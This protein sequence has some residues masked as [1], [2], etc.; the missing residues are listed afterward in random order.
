MM[1]LARAQAAAD[2]PD[3]QWPGSLVLRLVLVAMLAVALSGVLSAWLASRASERESIRRLV[4]QQTEEVE[5]M[6]RLLASKIEQSQKV[7]RTVAEGITPE[8]LNS[9]SSLEW[10]LQQG[11]PAVQFFDSMQVARQDGALRVNLHS[12]RLEDAANLDPSERDA[13]RRTL[14]GGKP[15]VSELVAG[16]TAEARVMFTMPLRREDGSVMGVVA[17]ALKLQSQ[18]LLPPSMTLPARDDSRLIVFTRDGTILSHPDPLRILG[19]VRDETGLGPVYTGW[20]QQAQPV[21]GRGT[22]EV[23]PAHIVSMAGMP[24]PQWFVARVSDARAMLAPLEGAQRKA[25]WLA[26]ALIGASMALLAGLMVWMAQP[27]AQLCHSA[28]QLA[29]AQRGDGIAWP[30]A[31]GEV[32]ALVQVF[33]GQVQHSAQQRQQRD[34]LEGQFQ[35]IL[36]NASVG[37]VIT[38]QGI[39]EVVGRQ[40]CQMLGYTT[41]ELQGRAA[42]TLYASDEDYA[43]LGERVQADFAAHAAFDGDVCFM[44][45]DG[46]PVWARVQGR[47][48]RPHDM[49][50]GTVWI[51]EDLTAAREAQQQQ[52]WAAIHD[53]LTQLCNREAFVQRMGV[54]L[55]ERSARARAPGIAAAD[56]AE[57]EGDGV[58]LFLDLDYFTVVNDVA[59]HDAGDDVLRHVARL[60]ESQV[61]QIGWAARLGGDEFAVVLPGCS[62]ARGQ[63]LA[64]QLRAAVQ[65]WEPSY[66]GRSF[67]LGVSIGLVVLDASLQDVPSVLYAADMACNDAKRAGRNRVETRHADQAAASGRMA[68]G[69]V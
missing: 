2:S 13:L 10:L 59:G 55:A 44:R 1:P 38:R 5:V 63:A 46:S 29:R 31:S 66:Q 47:G 61:R 24:L 22:T 48:V 3:W 15:L 7:L 23:L 11:L 45:K 40:A 32:G 6:A 50:G 53:P 35:A 52:D 54:L 12:G 69:P 16:R 36:E 18:G 4:G 58:M 34:Q 68:L 62:L 60:L 25:W 33:E 21:A 26:A 41:E 14:T 20:L 43:R 49:A 37:I 9:P 65:A 27:L 42:R 30:R 51:L 39:L 28:L 17:G 57:G 67:T 8:M 56:A 64:E 19:N